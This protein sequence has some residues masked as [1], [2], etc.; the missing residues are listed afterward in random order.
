LSRSQ[1]I[2]VLALSGL[3]AAGPATAYD[4][5]FTVSPP[6]VGGTGFRDGDVQYRFRLAYRGYRSGDTRLSGPL[7]SL[8]R[9]QALSD[10]L[11]VSVGGTADHLTGTDIILGDKDDV[12]RWQIDLHLIGEL[13]QRLTQHW[14]IILFL[15]PKLGVGGYQ[16]DQQEAPGEHLDA[17]TQRSGYVVG[18]QSPLHLGSLRLTP[19]ATFE[20]LDAHHEVD[21]SL[22]GT[23]SADYTYEVLQYGLEGS[24][25]GSS[26]TMGATFRE[27]KIGQRKERY[28]LYELGYGF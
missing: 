15:G 6:P 1:L 16:V 12:A 14:G 4:A 22:S 13:Q 3:L 18:A 11:A 9:R 10:R 17:S 25:A 26:V 5:R 8:H 19:F 7:L 24:L 27:V 21:S 28:I 23:S 2:A 20:E